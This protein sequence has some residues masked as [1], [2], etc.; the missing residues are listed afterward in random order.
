MDSILKVKRSSVADKIPV[1]ADLEQGELALNTADGKLY[2]KKE[3]NVVVELGAGSGLPSGGVET[4]IL[5]MGV[6]DP[7][8]S[9]DMNVKKNIENTAEVT[10]GLWVGSRSQYD[11]IIVK[12]S[13]V[14]YFV[15]EV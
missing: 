12:D 6:T 9:P 3:D 1:E 13:S 11:G 5:T 7:Q 4:D 2:T 14:I 10:N 15:K 8:W